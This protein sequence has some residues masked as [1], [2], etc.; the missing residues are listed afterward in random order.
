MII[1]GIFTID[2][3]KDEDAGGFN[4]VAEV[5]NDMDKDM[6]FELFLT[7]YL[8]AS[9]CKIKSGSKVWGIADTVTGMGT[10]LFGFEDADVDYINRA[11]Y[12]YTKTLTVDGA[13]TMK[14]KLDV[15]KDIKSTSGDVVATTISLKGHT[16]PI[17]AA[18]FTGVIN[19]QTGAA[20]GTISGNT[21]K[22]V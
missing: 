3:L 4:R 6:C 17:T 21:E 16:H 10:A 8:R 13:V 20:T 14:D 1:S 15:T 9:Q 12:H 19:P 22:P 7:P 5:H 18:H 11:E 2:E